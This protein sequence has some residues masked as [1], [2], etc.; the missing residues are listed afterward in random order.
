MYKKSTIVANV[1][2]LDFVGEFSFVLETT[3]DCH[4]AGPACYGCPCFDRCPNHEELD[5]VEA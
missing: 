4:N 5:P 2:T 3:D 1:A